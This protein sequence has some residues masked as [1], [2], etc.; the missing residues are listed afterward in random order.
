MN[1]REGFSV[2][3]SVYKWLGNSFSKMQNLKT[4]GAADVQ[5]FDIN[6]DTFLAFASSMPGQDLESDSLIFKWGGST[7]SHFQSITTHI[8]FSLHP[9]VMCGETYIGVAN[10]F[11]NS[12]VYKYSGTYFIFF[13][14]QELFIK[15]V[16]GL[17]SFEHKGHTYLAFA[18][19]NSVLYKWV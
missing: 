11:P 6:G 7:F 5:S 3:S 12:G 10:L 17:T 1:L 15:G 16:S 4:N 9:F 18:K 13:K 19:N 8:A 14:Y 2:E